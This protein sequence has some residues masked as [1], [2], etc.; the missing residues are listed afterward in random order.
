MWWPRK[1]QCLPSHEWNNRRNHSSSASQRNFPACHTCSN[2]HV[3][4]LLGTQR[5]VWF[6]VRRW[7]TLLFTKTCTWNRVTPMQLPRLWAHLQAHRCVRSSC[8]AH[9]CPPME[10]TVFPHGLEL[11]A[12]A[13]QTCELSQ[14]GNRLA[15]VDHRTHVHEGVGQNP[16]QQSSSRLHSSAW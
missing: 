3:G 11:R 10:L 5:K 16:R 6:L 12:R 2:W 9:A 4:A 8:S 15:L 7:S 14:G 1:K 13:Q